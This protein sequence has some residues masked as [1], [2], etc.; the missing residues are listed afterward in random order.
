MTL[1]PSVDKRMSYP[2]LQRQVG[3]LLAVP[4]RLSTVILTFGVTRTI[5]FRPVP[6]WGLLEHH[7]AGW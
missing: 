2:V 5:F 4:A 7:R 3:S 6:P 1:G